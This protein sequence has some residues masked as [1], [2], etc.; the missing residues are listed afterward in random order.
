MCYK[1]MGS[2]KQGNQHRKGAWEFPK[3]KWRKNLRLRATHLAQQAVN[4]KQENGRKS[5]GKTISMDRLI[6]FTVWKQYWKNVN[7]MKN[8]QQVNQKHQ[9][10]PDG[11][12]GKGS[13]YN[14]KELGSIPSLGWSPGGGHG[15]PL[16]CSGLENPY[17]Q[18]SLAGYSPWGH[19]E[20]DMSETI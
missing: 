19:K 17:R 20:S 12:D 6:D 13:A 1:L 7:N 14:A 3:G 5:S 4:P 8:E 2:T 11:S 16:H 10:F 18:R 15:K 9:G